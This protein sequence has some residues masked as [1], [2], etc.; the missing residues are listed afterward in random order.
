MVTYPFLGQAH[1]F[2]AILGNKKSEFKPHLPEGV[3]QGM[4]GFLCELEQ[5]FPNLGLSF[6]R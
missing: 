3:W 2:C 4:E 6:L 5:C 1:Q